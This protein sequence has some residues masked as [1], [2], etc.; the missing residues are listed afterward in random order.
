MRVLRL[1]F[2]L[3]ICVISILMASCTAVKTVKPP[4]ITK[5][6]DLLVNCYYYAPHNHEMLSEYIDADLRKMVSIGTDI[7]TIC[8]QEDQLTNWHQQRVKNF[9][10]QAHGV[11]LKVHVVPNR[12]AG[13]LAGWLDGYSSWTLKNQDTWLPEGGGFSDPKNPKVI[14]L[15]KKN[16]QL[17][18][19][20]FKVD[21]IIW[22]EPRPYKNL[23]VF[24]FLDDMSK[25]AKSLN[26]KVAMSIFAAS[27]AIHLADVFPKLKNMDF[28]GSDGH[29]RSEDHKMNRMKKTIFEAHNA[30]YPPLKA[31]GI[32]TFFLLEAQRHRDPDLQNYIDNLDKALILPMEHLMYYYSAS[33][34]SLSNEKIFNEATWR[35][36]AALKGIKYKKTK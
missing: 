18:I 13:L 23:D 1:N 15:Y 34:M 24:Y 21:G 3:A 12:W 31:A 19:E 6:K 22:D 29:V 16:I 14:A 30:F 26:P 4:N 33:E 35:A 28:A 17:L 10:S 5:N 9:I 20:E 27:E 25:Y 36:V 11:G 7:V 32:K 8:I 2:K